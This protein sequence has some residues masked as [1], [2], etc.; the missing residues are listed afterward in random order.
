MAE[1]L[2]G[3]RGEEVLAGAVGAALL[4]ALGIGSPTGVGGTALTIAVPGRHPQLP[5]EGAFGRADAAAAVPILNE[6]PLGSL[7]VVEMVMTEAADEALAG[8]GATEA[9]VDL[10]EQ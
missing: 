10:A 9:V 4:V 6:Q 1:Q 8:A 2:V 7:D 3:M 5:G